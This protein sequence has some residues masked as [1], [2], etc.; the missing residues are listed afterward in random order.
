MATVPS[1][2]TLQVAAS[3]VPTA[4]LNAYKAAIDFLMRN[5]S[6]VAPG[7]LVYCA[8]ATNTIG[9]ASTIN[10]A[11]DTEVDDS[12]GMH[13]GSSS[14]VTVVTAGRFVFNAQ[15]LF[16]STSTSRDGLTLLKTAAIGGTTSI[17]GQCTLPGTTAAHVIQVA[18]PCEGVELLVGDVV[19]LQ[20]FSTAGCTLT[21]GSGTAPNVTYNT[22]LSW[23]WLSL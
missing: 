21:N 23:K 11:L 2:P 3:E 8:S 17:I 20:A 6:N 9:A 10:V 16:P 4:Q 5:G 14:G 22:W 19:T 1:S 18:S 15:A 12:D 13:V 7:G